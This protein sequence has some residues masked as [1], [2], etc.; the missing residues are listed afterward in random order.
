MAAAKKQSYV[1]HYGLP[2]METGWHFLTGQQVPILR[3]ANTVGYQFRCDP[4]NDLF[5]HPTCVIILTPEGKVARYLFAFAIRTVGAPSLDLRLG[6]VEA[7]EHKIGTPEIDRALLFCYRYDPDTGK[8]TMTA[9][10]LVRR[11]GALTVVVLASLVWWHGDGEWRNNRPVDPAIGTSEPVAGTGLP[12]GYSGASNVCRNTSVSRTSLDHSERVDTLFFFLCAVCGTMAVSVAR[13]ICYFAFKYRRRARTTAPHASPATIASNGSGPL[14]RCSSSSSCSSGGRTSIR[15]CRAAAGCSGN[16]R[17]R[18]AV[19]V[20]DPASRRPARDQRAARARRPARQ[21]DADLRGRHPRL[22]RAGFPHPDRRDARPLLHVWFQP[23]KTGRYH[24]FC[25]QYCGTNHAGMVGP[26]VVMERATTRTGWTSTP[27]ARWPCRAARCFSN[28][29]ASPAIAPMRKPARCWRE[30][31]GRPVHLR[32]GRTVVAD[33]DYLRESI[34]YP[35]AK[36]VQGWETIMPTFKGQVSE[37]ER[38]LAD[39]LHQVAEPGQT[40][41]GRGVPAATRSPKETPRARGNPKPP[42]AGPDQSPEGK[43]NRS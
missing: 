30:L 23:T 6:L 17:R 36:V 31:Y 12:A 11:A 38:Q 8:Y 1:E 37:E 2:G 15:R 7:S 34:L 29:S 3:L 32:D 9:M 26:V 39:R 21:A 40:P 20:E 33:D 13:L 4:K 25:S 24:L 28:R 16:L 19:D 43:S 14:R 42:H 35:G 27:K 18:Q 41:R 22:L 5:A 10:N